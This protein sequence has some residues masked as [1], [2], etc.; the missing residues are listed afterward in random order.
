[1]LD[2]SIKI[3]KDLNKL[4]NWIMDKWRQRQVETEAHK[5]QNQTQTENKG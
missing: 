5:E 1:M 3:Q 2:D 4:E